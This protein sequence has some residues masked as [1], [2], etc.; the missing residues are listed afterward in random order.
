MSLP[1]L[2]C[3]ACRRDFPPRPLLFACPHARS[4][5]EH[6][7]ERLPDAGDGLGSR[8]RAAWS[9]GGR[10]TFAV[11]GELLSAR[12]LL[13]PDA[14]GELLGSLSERLERLEGRCFEATPLVAA[15]ALSEAIGRTGPLWIKNDT[16]NIAGS[17]KGRH[18]MATL[19]YLEALRE[20]DG[21][22]AKKVL[23]VYSC[24]NA[25]LAAAAVARAGGYE[26][27]AFVPEEVDPAVARLLAERGAVVEKIAR[28]ATGGGD[29]CYLAFQEALSS[30]GWLPFACA[31]NDNWSNIEGGATL[32]WEMVMQLAD[33]G[34]TLDSAVIQVGGGALARAVAQALQEAAALGVMKQ[35]PRLHVC[36]PEGGFPF[37]R[38]YF[39]VLREIAR[40][41]GIAFDLDYDPAAPP[42]A[43]LARLKHFSWSCRDQ[44]RAL[45]EF[46]R[47]HFDTTAVQLVLEEAALLRNRYMWPWD[48][49]EP[50]SLAHGIL[51][52][53]TYDWYALLRAVLRSGGGAEILR[54]E[55]IRAA[56]RLS[57]SHTGI[58]VCPTG[59][60]GLAGLIQLSEAGVVERSEK[61][62][63]FFTGIDRSREG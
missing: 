45:A 30:R 16:G 43:W 44:T 26:L 15:P 22:Q 20:L 37:V 52:D 9:D 14:Y 32:G 5:E 11:F 21:V 24:G 62:G 50:H 49:P 61:V 35:A 47:L 28:R 25:A 8:L 10:R 58:P 57:R 1:P 13:G 23:A 51:D 41:N 7:L 29:P 31:G 36:Q 17:H 19:L 48:G 33:R 53:V 59:A 60:A 12:R 3:P 42:A 63:L 27:H 56:H 40:R 46:A 38:A 2:R 39:L 54:E 4:G 6:T 55:S 18:L 34:E